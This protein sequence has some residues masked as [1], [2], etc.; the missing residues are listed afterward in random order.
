MTNNRKHR[1]HRHRH[2]HHQGPKRFI[3]VL[4]NDLLIYGA[5]KLTSEK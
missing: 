3:F 5:Q 4:F 2:C 1:R